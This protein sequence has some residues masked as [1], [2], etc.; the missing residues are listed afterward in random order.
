MMSF[1]GVTPL[2]HFQRWD[3]GGGSV[4]RILYTGIE[5]EL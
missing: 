3:F 5:I 1:G 4:R 2:G